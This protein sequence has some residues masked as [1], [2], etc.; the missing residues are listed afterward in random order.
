MLM[1]DKYRKSLLNIKKIVLAMG[2]QKLKAAPERL[3]DW[4]I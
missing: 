4:D 2:L 3:L 1:K